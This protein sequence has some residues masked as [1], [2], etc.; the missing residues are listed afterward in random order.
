MT[1]ATMEQYYA[2][3]PQKRMAAGIVWFDE[4]YRLVIGR[5]KINTAEAGK[6]SIPGGVVEVGESPLAGAIRESKEEMGLNAKTPRILAVHYLKAAG[7]RT[8]SI[9]F[10]FLGAILSAE[11]IRALRLPEGSEWEEF[12]LASSDE[13]RTLLSPDLSACVDDWISAAREGT[14]FYVET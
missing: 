14:T 2:T 6:W 1:T 12:R 13:A 7:V 3:R 10:Y 5:P 9:Q 8:E 11:D 4:A